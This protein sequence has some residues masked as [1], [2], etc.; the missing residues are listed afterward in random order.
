MNGSLRVNN[1]TFKRGV[2]IKKVAIIIKILANL[3]LKMFFS[4]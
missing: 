1:F 4:K 3:K 2:K